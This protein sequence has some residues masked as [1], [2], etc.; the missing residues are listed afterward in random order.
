MSADYTDFFE[1]E[2]DSENINAEITKLV[3]K[4]SAL[5]EEAADL[6]AKLSA[7]N[8]QILAIETT[9]IPDALL[10]AGV[11]EVK[12]IDGLKVST[13]LFVGGIP[14]ERKESVYDWL[15]SHGHG[16]IIKRSLSLNF[17]KGEDEVVAAASKLLEESGFT[18]VQ[19]K[20]VNYQTFAST[21]RDLV[22]RGVV[23]PLEEWGVY[24][25]Q[26]AVIRK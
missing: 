18:P 12:T 3:R 11:T 24:Y 20:D 23:P 14:A 5:S 1:E 25:G 8:K 21:M 16:D 6:S 13:K 2:P 15:D 26:K 17:G 19:K 7:I 4:H 10:A 9:E 22:S